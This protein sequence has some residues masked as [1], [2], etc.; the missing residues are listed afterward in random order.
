MIKPFINAANGILAFARSQWNFKVHLLATLA[1]IPVGIYFKLSTTD[2]AILAL[3]AAGVWV[4]EMLNTALEVLLNHLHPDQHPA[5]GKAKDIAAGA[6]L[7][8]AGF[9]IVVGALVFWEK[10][11]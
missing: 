7:V 4:S 11:F 9:A 8:A 3:A 5:I 6:V 2:W 10:V 1:L